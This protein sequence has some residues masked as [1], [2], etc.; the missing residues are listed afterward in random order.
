MFPMGLQ[1]HV[2]NPQRRRVSTVV[3][4]WS[5]WS[6]LALNP[7]VWFDA[8]DTSS[9]TSSNGKVSQWNDKSGFN[10]N[11]SQSTDANQPT[12]GSVTQNGLNTIGFNGS[13]QFIQ[14]SSALTFT[15]PTSG[16]MWFLS[17]FVSSSSGTVPYCSSLTQQTEAMIYQQSGT[18]GAWR[19]SAF[20]GSAEAVAADTA[21]IVTGN[22]D[23]ANSFYRING[24]EV[25]RGTTGT[26][27]GGGCR[28][29]RNPFSAYNGGQLCEFAAVNGYLHPSAMLEWEKY[30]A[31][32]WGIAI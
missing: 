9:I 26:G 11:L 23:G 31:T 30:A 17:V 19:N 6:P 25:A 8:S 32:K 12:T 22:F 7:S 14:T 15:N 20:L 13:T 28:I 2:R 29:G 10:R 21:Y 3:Q 16:N 1:T 24:K 5:T 27:A 18:W 4:S